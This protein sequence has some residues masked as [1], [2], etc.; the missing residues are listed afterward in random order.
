MHIDEIIEYK[1]ENAAALTDSAYSIFAAP[2]F[3]TDFNPNAKLSFSQSAAFCTYEYKKEPPKEFG[4]IMQSLK[5]SSDIPTP[6]EDKT[7]RGSFGG[8]NSDGYDWFNRVLDDDWDRIMKIS[9]YTS[10]YGEYEP[11]YAYALHVYLDGELADTIKTG[12]EFNGKY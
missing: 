2:D 9:S 12:E 10:L 6:P 1:I 7:M 11:P 5:T 3:N 8:G 4:L